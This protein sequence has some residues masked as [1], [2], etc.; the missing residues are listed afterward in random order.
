MNVHLLGY[1][2]IVIGLADLALAGWLQRQLHNASQRAPTS[3]RRVT[4][5][6]RGSGLIALIAGAA[7]VLLR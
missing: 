7:L 3:A 2:L 1:L 5:L 4:L 6:T